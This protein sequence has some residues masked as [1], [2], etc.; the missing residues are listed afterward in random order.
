MPKSIRIQDLTSDKIVGLL[1]QAEIHV[2]DEQATAIQ[3]FVHSAGGLDQARFAVESL[4]Q[5]ITAA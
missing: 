5:L 2:T 4:A 3:Q 1:A